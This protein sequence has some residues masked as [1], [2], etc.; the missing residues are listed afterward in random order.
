MLDPPFSGDNLIIYI[1]NIDTEYP[2]F[3]K[4]YTIDQIQGYCDEYEIKLNVKEVEDG[5]KPAG[6]IL[7]QSKSEGSKIAKGDEI[8]IEVTK[9]P[10]EET[11]VP[12]GDEEENN[13]E[14]NNQSN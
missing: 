10:I 2:N 12:Y 13:N 7:S 5:D 11:L 4:N 8:T 14:E 9:K 6:T 3:Q 1:P